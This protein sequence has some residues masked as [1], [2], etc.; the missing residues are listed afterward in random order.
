MGQ[1]SVQVP[2]TDT[3]ENLQ[4]ESRRTRGPDTARMYFVIVCS[5]N[6]YL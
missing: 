5:L 2:K 1:R 6:S 3:C 4:E